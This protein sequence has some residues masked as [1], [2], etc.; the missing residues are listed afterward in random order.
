MKTRKLFWFT[1]F[2]L[3]TS[4][5]LSAC[6]AKE[7][8]PT[9]T[10][11]DA[12]AIAVQ[13]IQTFSMGLTMTAFAQPTATYTPVPPTGTNTPPTFAIVGTGSPAAQP[14]SACNNSLWIS[15][16]TVPDNTVMAPGKQFTKTWLV[17]NIGTC[18]W[19]P[20]FKVA[21]G[22]IGIPMGG[23]AAPIGKTVKPDEQ[24]EIS[25]NLV[26]PSAAGDA[27]SY[28]KLQ[29]E[30]GVFFGTFLTVVIKVVGA[31]ATTG[32]PTEEPSPT[33]PAP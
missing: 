14:T 16:V 20:N 25:V 23:Q 21:F 9:P 17:K 4:L 31:P 26:A 32:T 15:D 24:V 3:V 7:Q 29:D 22:G 1:T 27:L 12:N 8:Q 18:T 28:W 33:S 2:L 19:T 5:V 13:A 11:I 10:P 6:G 30:K